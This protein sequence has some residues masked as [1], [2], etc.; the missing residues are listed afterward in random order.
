M[1]RK[2]SVR[3]PLPQIPRPATALHQSKTSDEPDTTRRRSLAGTP[4]RHGSAHQLIRGV[5]CGLGGPGSSLRGIEK[6]IKRKLSLQYRIPDCTTDGKTALAPKL[7]EAIITT[8]EFIPLEVLLEK[9]ALDVDESNRVFINED[10]AVRMYEARCIDNGLQSTPQRY[11]K[12]RDLLLSQC[13]GSMWRLHGL[14]LKSESAR[15]VSSILKDNC[16]YTVLDL[17]G[18]SLQDDGACH[19]ADL[20][21]VSSYLVHISLRSNNIS[22]V[23]AEAICNA[24]LVNVT[25]TSLDL[26]GEIGFSR[27][28]LGKEGAKSIS[29]V[30]ESNTTLHCLDL[31]C[32]AI[33]SKGVAHL[34]SGLKKNFSIKELFLSENCLMAD[35]CKVL[36]NSVGTAGVCDLQ[37]FSISN[38]KIGDNGVV[39]LSKFI[40]SLHH[41]SQ[42]DFSNVGMTNV[43]LEKLSVVIQ[44]CTQLECLKLDN[45]NICTEQTDYIEK[46]SIISGLSYLEKH[47]QK[48]TNNLKSLSLKNCGMQ[49]FASKIIASMI[50]TCRLTYLSIS[51]NEF[52]TS[53]MINIF[54]E[55]S[56]NNS[57]T[58][59][60]CSN[61]Q[62]GPEGEIF[63]AESLT[64]NHTL[65]HLKCTSHG[66]IHSIKE[67]ANALK[68]NETLLFLDSKAPEYQ[69]S[70]RRNRELCKA[71]RT[72]RYRHQICEMEENTRE[73]SHHLLSI[74]NSRGEAA[75]QEREHEHIKAGHESF[76]NDMR[77]EE[78]ML[79]SQLQDCKDVAQAQRDLVEDG[80]SALAAAAKK[81][82]RQ[83]AKY[84]VCVILIRDCNFFDNE[85]HNRK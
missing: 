42:I 52:C 6:Q 73:L 14:G 20:I 59:F 34:A 7:S 8:S 23:G 41:L 44:S 4:Q 16:N 71:S 27:N 37:L 65:Q 51:Q 31:S 17:S 63:L 28:L 77:F 12:F 48:K 26:S 38:N 54:N 57:L 67:F 83:K 5:S 10:Q 49:E 66:A 24:L 46:R 29:K 74:K 53:G 19:I 84:N 2:S 55:L 3:S 61:T 35:S 62:M 58:S 85:K 36:S 81:N 18:N 11:I 70:L 33:G 72:L 64:R 21:E 76:L 68:Q 43:G 15:I 32:T 45:N 79:Q 39:N 1:R 13:S 50:K 80:N 69:A 78:E 82:D 47:L 30:L 56:I 25:V 75:R 9:R 40:Q 22:H 60:D